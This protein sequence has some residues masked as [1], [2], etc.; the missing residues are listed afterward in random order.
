M[1][2]MK[3]FLDIS[4]VRKY[5]YKRAIHLVVVDHLHPK[6]ESADLWYI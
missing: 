4:R 5:L 2:A 6:I 3:V 1:I